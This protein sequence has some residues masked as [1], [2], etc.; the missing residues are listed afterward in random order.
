MFLRQIF[1]YSSLLFWPCK[2][3][4][5]FASKCAQNS[6]LFLSHA[7]CQG[8]SDYLTCLRDFL[9][10]SSTWALLWVVPDWSDYILSPFYFASFLDSSTAMFVSP[11]SHS[12]SWECALY[13]LGAGLEHTTS[14]HESLIYVNAGCALT[15][16]TEM[17]TALFSCHICF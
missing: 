2:K 8:H 13:I 14:W 10:A 9:V 12:F 15:V 7:A 3:M 4:G 16:C 17:G 11:S 5:N 6:A 1:D